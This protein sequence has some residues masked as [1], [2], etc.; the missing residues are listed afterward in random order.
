MVSFFHE[1]LASLYKLIERLLHLSK[2]EET[3]IIAGKLPAIF[4]D[5]I[6][7]PSDATIIGSVIYKNEWH[8]RIQVAFDV[9][10]EL[11]ELNNFYQDNLGRNWEKREHFKGGFRR[12]YQSSIQSLHDVYFIDQSQ[13]KE[14]YLDACKTQLKSQKE[15]II[16]GSLD[17][18]QLI[19]PRF[20]PPQPP[21][22][23]LT[24]PPNVTILHGSG[25]GGEKESTANAHLETSLDL[26]ELITHYADCFERAGWVENDSGKKENFV[27]RNWKMTDENNQTWLGV[28]QITSLAEAEHYF[29]SARVSQQTNL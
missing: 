21:F 20:R 9:S 6:P 29:A 28:L 5:D 1:D 2:Y 18:F 3:Q 24:S 22:P 15:S 27:W 11:E 23:T 26:S 17:L 12:S 16:M 14:I 8:E 19:N 7:F 4:P 10:I 13:H 25:G